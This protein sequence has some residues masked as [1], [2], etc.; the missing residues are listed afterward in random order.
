VLQFGDFC[1]Q[2]CAECVKLLVFNERG[3][4]PYDGLVALQ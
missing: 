1:F 4:C 2:V 3:L